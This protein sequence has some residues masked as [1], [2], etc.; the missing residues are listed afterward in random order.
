MNILKNIN[1]ILSLRNVDIEDVDEILCFY[2]KEHNK[3]FNQ[4]LLKGEFKL[5]FNDNEDCKY[6]ITGMIDDRT[7]T[8]WSSY[9]RDAIKNF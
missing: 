4:G 8:S 1:I 2:M 3:V 7:F 6:I 5:V 9:L